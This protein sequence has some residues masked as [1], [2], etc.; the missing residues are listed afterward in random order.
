MPRGTPAT[1]SGYCPV[2]A[3]SPQ[4]PDRPE[5]WSDPCLPTLLSQGACPPS[6]F[7]L[8]QNQASMQSHMY[9]LTPI[10]CDSVPST[11]VNVYCDLL[12]P[13]W[14]SKPIWMARFPVLH[15]RS[16]LVRVPCLCRCLHRLRAPKPFQNPSR[17]PLARGP[18]KI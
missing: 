8:E 16:F 17:I 4:H 6:F 12:A 10:C 18:S 15:M 1:G 2:P 7:C 13:V 11:S 5:P 14:P 3:Q 9:H